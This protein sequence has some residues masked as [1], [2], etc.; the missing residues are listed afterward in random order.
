MIA[1]WRSAPSLEPSRAHCDEHDLSCHAFLVH[2]SLTRT[3]IPRV[4]PRDV[5]CQTLGIPCW[6]AHVSGGDNHQPRVPAD[7][8][9]QNEE[10]MERYQENLQTLGQWR[11]Q[12]TRLLPV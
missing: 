11:K 1:S 5:V 9:Q 6:T 4:I 10:Q 3:G 2:S 12:D 8:K 7:R